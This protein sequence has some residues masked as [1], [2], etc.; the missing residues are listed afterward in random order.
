M[1]GEMHGRLRAANVRHEGVHQTL[2]VDE[3]LEDAQRTQGPEDQAHRSGGRASRRAA[4]GVR[5]RHDA[6]QALVLIGQCRDPQRDDTRLVAQVI[7]RRRTPSGDRHGHHEFAGL[8]AA[9]PQ[10]PAIAPVTAARM[11]SLSLAPRRCA[12]SRS[13]VNGTRTVVSRRRGPVGRLSEVRA[14][15]CRPPGSDPEFAQSRRDRRGDGAGNLAEGD[16][17]VPPGSGEQRPQ[18]RWR[19]RERR[20]RPDLGRHPP[21]QPGR[22]ARRRR[23]SGRGA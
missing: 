11:R 8:F 9:L 17:P 10:H 22:R 12:V 15:K 5:H 18:P 20:R 23:R 14:T 6:P 1:P 16:R 7:G 4:A 3:E 2:V 19:L 13:G 21:A